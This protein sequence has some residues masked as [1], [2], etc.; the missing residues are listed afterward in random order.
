MA[1][2]RWNSGFKAISKIDNNGNMLV[3][4]K[5]LDKYPMLL[6]ELKHMGVEFKLYEVTNLND[7]LL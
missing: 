7:V 2:Y 5:Y 3:L 6:R 4:K 1:S